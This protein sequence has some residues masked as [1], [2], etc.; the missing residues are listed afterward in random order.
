[1]GRSWEEIA[2]GKQEGYLMIVHHAGWLFSPPSVLNC[3][4]SARKKTCRPQH[5]ELTFLELVK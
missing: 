2:S 3:Y 1:M 5:I 4:L